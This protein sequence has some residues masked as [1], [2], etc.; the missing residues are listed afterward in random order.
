[1]FWALLLEIWAIYNHRR[2]LLLFN[3]TCWSI[4]VGKKRRKNH[5][6]ESIMCVMLWKCSLRQLCFCPGNLCEDHAKIL[7]VSL[8]V[9]E[10]V[11][12]PFLEGINTQAQE[13]VPECSIACCWKSSFAEMCSPGKLKRWSFSRDCNAA[14]S[15]LWQVFNWK[16]LAIK[17]SLYN[18]TLC[19]N[20]CPCQKSSKSTFLAK[21][22]YILRSSTLTKLGLYEFIVKKRFWTLVI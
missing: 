7:C 15:H 18:E 14:C 16:S 8:F 17:P 6:V 1:M 21:S 22:A 10:S 2:W 20:Q 13:H 19:R 12:S 5:V 3:C 11:S 4:S 9:A